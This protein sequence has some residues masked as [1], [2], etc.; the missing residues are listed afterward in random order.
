MRTAWRTCPVCLHS[1]AMTRRQD[2]VAGLRGI[3]EMT[4][5]WV[6]WWVG[7]IIVAASIIG[8]LWLIVAGL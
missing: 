7:T 6:V 8:A 5:G 4:V 3:A 2:L 1:Q